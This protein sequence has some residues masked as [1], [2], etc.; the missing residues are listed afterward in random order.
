M[1]VIGHEYNHAISNRMVGGPDAGITGYQGGS[2]GESWGDQVALEYLFEHGYSTGTSPAV[3]GAY[4]TGNPTTGIRNYALDKNPLHYGDLGYDV[5]GP[6]VHADGE[7]WS[8]VM[9]DV[10][11]LFMERY[12]ATF[13]SSDKALQLRCSQGNTSAQPP[14]PPLLLASAPATGAGC[15]CSSTPTCSSSPTRACSTRVMRCWQPT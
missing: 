6:E 4:V 5:T 15:S 10:R 12:D 13:P 2:M 3:E 9:W 14:Q 11:R 7:P 8:A 1:S